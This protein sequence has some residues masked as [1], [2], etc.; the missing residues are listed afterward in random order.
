MVPI[1][2]PYGFPLR[3]TLKPRRFFQER[4]GQV[5]DLGVSAEDLCGELAEDE[6]ATKDAWVELLNWVNQGEQ[7]LLVGGLEHEFF[8]FPFSWEE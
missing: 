3:P 1:R 5:P 7:C 2:F 6:R 4:R 8:D